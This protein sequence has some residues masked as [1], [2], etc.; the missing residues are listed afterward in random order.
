MFD[1]EDEFRVWRII[2]GIYLI[3]F[4][5]MGIIILLKE[6]TIKPFQ[7]KKLIYVLFALMIQISVTISEMFIYEKSLS[8]FPIIAP[9]FPAIGLCIIWITSFVVLLGILFK[10]RS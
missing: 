10:D 4:Y 1:A 2:I 5:G 9:V 7:M 3:P 8:Y 6:L